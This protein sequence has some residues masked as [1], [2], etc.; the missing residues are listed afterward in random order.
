MERF[1]HFS[2]LGLPY[3]GKPSYYSESGYISL[4]N[5]S[6]TY[7]RKQLIKLQNENWIDEKT[8]TIF[9]EL[10]AYNPGYNY[11][12]IIKLSLKKTEVGIFEPSAKIEVYRLFKY[13][14]IEKGNAKAFEAFFTLLGIILLIKEVYYLGKKKLSYFKNIWKFNDFLI[15]IWM[16]VTNVVF[17]VRMAKISETIKVL[18]KTNGNVYI[19]FEKVIKLEWVF[20]FSLSITAVLTTLKIIE[21][22]RFNNHVEAMSRTLK[23]M[24]VCLC[25]YFVFFAAFVLP[26]HL[27]FGNDDK[28]EIIDLMSFALIFQKSPLLNHRKNV[29][30]FVLLIY[31]IFLLIGM[32][33][34]F[35]IFVMI[36][37]TEYLEAKKDSSKTEVNQFGVYKHFKKMT[38]FMK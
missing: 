32:I 30:T 9:V 13:L 20:I 19:N 29:G 16:T 4:L 6:K 22:L 24:F 26:F 15:V 36:A 23:W 21:F 2:F 7:I 12:G 18:E 8:K 38:L 11:F 17:Y 25:Y 34:G 31:Y 27:I 37:T 3:F 14:N 33:G 5:G 10:V 1:F 28:F 35:A